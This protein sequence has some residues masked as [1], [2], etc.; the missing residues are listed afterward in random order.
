MIRP[1]MTFMVDF[2]LLWP[3][4]IGA[5]KN[6]HSQLTIVDYLETRNKKV[7]SSSAHIHAYSDS[8]M[9]LKMLPNFCSILL[10]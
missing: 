1:D 4:I 5:S 2:I 7:P 3:T 6:I 8:L 9:P 10:N